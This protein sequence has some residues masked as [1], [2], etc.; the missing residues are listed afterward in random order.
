M[1]SAYLE[2]RKAE[3]DYDSGGANNGSSFPVFLI[4]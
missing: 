1:K 4:S 2:L 3:M